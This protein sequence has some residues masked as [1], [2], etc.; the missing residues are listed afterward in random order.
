MR[1]AVRTSTFLFSIGFHAALFGGLYC[2]S[3][4]GDTVPEEQVYHVALAELA[5]PPPAPPAAEPVPPPASE[6]EPV[7]PPPESVK[8]EP[9]KEP[10]KTPKISPRKKKETA[11][12]RKAASETPPPP[13][14]APRSVALPQAVHASGTPRPIRI[15]GLMAYETDDVDQRPSV[16]KNA[17]VEYPRKARRLGLSGRVLV[18]L[19][20]DTEGRPQSCKIRSAEPAGHFEEAALSAARAMRFIPGK[21][22]GHPVNTVVLIPFNFSLK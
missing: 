8:P 5:V 10:P 12:P 3:A 22:R 7:P 16:V 21:I 2:F 19:V 1:H 6:P 20:V 4:Q 14:A 13:P 9:K 15:G 18:Q 11:P 17:R